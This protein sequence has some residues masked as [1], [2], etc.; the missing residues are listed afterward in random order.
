[1]ISLSGRVAE[2]IVGGVEWSTLAR[3]FQHAKEC[4]I[5]S[6]KLKVMII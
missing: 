6:S 4:W 5:S 2:L 3:A 1:M